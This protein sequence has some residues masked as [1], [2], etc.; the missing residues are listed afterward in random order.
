MSATVPPTDGDDRLEADGVER[1]SA[2]PAPDAVAD[3]ARARIRRRVL[4]R[5]AADQG[6]LSVP[7]DGGTWRP[8]ADGVHIKVLHEH[9]GEMAYLLRLDAG[10]AIPPHRHPIDEECVVLEGRLRI[11]EA[12]ELGAGA[13]HLARAGSLHARISTDGGA[14]I[15]LRG[16]VPAAAD[17]L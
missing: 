5:I 1:L 9:D 2:Q 11:G 7:A 12:I 8:F 17:A 4:R 10:A 15:Y 6:H 16:A 14:T 13:F 3:A